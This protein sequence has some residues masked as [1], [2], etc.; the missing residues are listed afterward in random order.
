M[1]SLESGVLEFTTLAISLTLIVFGLSLL[2]FL[3]RHGGFEL[4]LAHVV[5][6][7]RRR[8]T[9]LWGLSVSLAALV[10]LGLAEGFG[11]LAGISQATVRVAETVLFAFGA[12]GLL[13]LMANA[14]RAPPLSFQQE[15]TLRENAQRA[16]LVE[17]PLLLPPELTDPSA[18]GPRR[19]SR[20]GR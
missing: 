1:A 6:D 19:P 4:G 5:T 14:L 2:A 15:W 18:P 13:T 17:T 3:P 12:A 16:R 7:H 10:G 11:P 9:F 20:P 8:A